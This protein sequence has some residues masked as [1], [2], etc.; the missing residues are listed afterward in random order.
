MLP[1]HGGSGRYCNRRYFTSSRAGHRAPANIMIVPGFKHLTRTRMG[2]RGFAA[3]P[4]PRDELV[5]VPVAA[6]DLA[7]EAA[8]LAG[9]HI[10]RPGLASHRTSQ[11]R[12]V[13]VELCDIGLQQ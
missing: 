12:R 6:H 4:G 3:L 9:V 11:R 2:L 10:P 1:V 7:A 5:D 8:A 13:P